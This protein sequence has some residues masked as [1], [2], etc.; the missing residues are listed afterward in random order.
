MC[1]IR[2]ITATSG[3]LALI[4]SAASQ[5]AMAGPVC[6]ELDLSSPC[7]RSNDIRASI[8]LGRVRR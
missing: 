4:L 8:V 1:I 6:D 7:V 5:P 3:A 2:S